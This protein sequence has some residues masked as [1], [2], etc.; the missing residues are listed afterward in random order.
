MGILY[1]HILV[2]NARNDISE[3]F[4]VIVLFNPFLNTGKNSFKA[5]QNNADDLSR[6]IK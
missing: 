6:K 2:K 3:R 5:E 4:D 1:L